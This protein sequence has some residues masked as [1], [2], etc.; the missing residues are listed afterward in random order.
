MKEINPSGI[1]RGDLVRHTINPFIYT[2]LEVIENG[3]LE[4]PMAHIPHAE[5]VALVRHVTSGGVGWVPV[6]SLELMKGKT[7]EI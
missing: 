1:T 4:T 6:R 7:D 2:V 3:T 5:L